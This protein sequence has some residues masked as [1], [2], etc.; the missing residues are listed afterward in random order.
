PECA[1]EQARLAARSRSKLD[2]DAA[3]A[4]ELGNLSAVDLEQSGFDARRVK[5]LELDDLLEQL[6][7]N[8]VIEEA[9][10]NAARRPPK[11]RQHCGGKIGLGVLLL[12][13]KPERMSRRPGGEVKG[14]IALHHASE[15]RRRPTNCQR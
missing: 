2:Q 3:L 8:R 9:A 12:R 15:A 5:L 4:G 7:A 6:R 10:R 13:A 1:D 14:D 11:A